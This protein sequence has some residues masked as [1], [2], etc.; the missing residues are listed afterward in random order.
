[1]NIKNYFRGKK[2]TVMGLDSKG[3]GLQDAKYLAEKDAEVVGTDLKK[4]EELSDAVSLAKQYKNLHLVLGEHRLGDFRNRD[5]IIRAALA[6]LD[7]P[8]LAEARKNN[9]PI[10]SDETLFLMYAP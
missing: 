1:M 7:S 10:V 6:P 5:F 3:R 2:I 4:A 9:I 8:Y